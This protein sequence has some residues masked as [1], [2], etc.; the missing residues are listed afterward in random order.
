MVTA[1]SGEDAVHYT[2][3]AKIAVRQYLDGPAERTHRALNGPAK[4]TK[5]PPGLNR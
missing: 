4:R 5:P 1:Q 2:P 3:R